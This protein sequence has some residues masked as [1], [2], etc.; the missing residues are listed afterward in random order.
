MPE[1]FAPS[2]PPIPSTSHRNSFRFDAPRQRSSV[3]P[4]FEITTAE[5]HRALPS[6][7]VEVAPI[8]APTPFEDPPTHA[9]STAVGYLGDDG[10]HAIF[11]QDARKLASTSQGG[12]APPFVPT[13]DLPPV[14]LQQ[15]FAETYFE[16]CWPWCPVLDKGT[17]WDSSDASP[18]PLLLNALALLGSRIRPPLIEHATAGEYYNRAKMLFYTDQE[19]N[20][21]VCLQAM[22]LFYWWAPRG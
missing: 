14:E 13:T 18:S 5:P 22:M 8:P 2:A 12:N 20:P 1:E 11:E 10:I 15:S 6:I 17:F 3:T 9:S 7:T 21:M 4:S 16:Y 19:S